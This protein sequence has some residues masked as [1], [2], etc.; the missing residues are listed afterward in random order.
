[1]YIYIYIY[2]YLLIYMQGRRRRA[3]PAPGAI[4]RSCLLIYN[5]IYMINDSCQ[6][7]IIAIINN[8]C[9]S[10]IIANISNSYQSMI[11]AIIDNSYYELCHLY[12]YPCPKK[13]YRLPAVLFCCTILFYKLAWAWAWV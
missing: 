4:I 11:I 13:F 7:I 6:S 8:S 1:M 3:D 5:D 12:P 9:Q 10:I 2:I